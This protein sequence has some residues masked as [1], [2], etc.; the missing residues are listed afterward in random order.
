LRGRIISFDSDNGQQNR[1]FLIVA[2]ALIGLICIGLMGLGAVIFLSRNNQAQDSVA[3]PLPTFTSLPPTI[4]PT[5]T[6]SATATNTPLPTPTGTPV[7]QRGDQQPASAPGEAQAGDTT[8]EPEA[9]EEEGGLQLPTVTP[10]GAT[11]TPTNT[12]VVQPPT[13]IA[14]A[15]TGTATPGAVSQIPN[16]GGI[17]PPANSNFLIWAGAGLLLILTLGAIYRFKSSPPEH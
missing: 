13:S 1:L 4:T 8:P 12:A 11:L 3:Q 5:D 2:L 16:S 15:V 7:V 9:T 6:P 17:I 10:G 14:A